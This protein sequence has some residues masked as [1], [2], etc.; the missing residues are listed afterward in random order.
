[1]KL[2]HKF[3]IGFALL[4]LLI[5]LF[6]GAV[7]ILSFFKVDYFTDMMSF[8]Q[9]RPF[10]VSGALFWIITAATGGILF[11][12]NEIV[13]QDRWSKYLLTGF[14]TL[15]MLTITTIL[16]SY[17]FEQY[18]GREYWEFPPFYNLLL[19]ISWLLL[20]VGFFVPIIRYASSKPVYIWMWSA[21][22]LFFL[23]TFIE[24]NLWHFAWF[25][26]SFVKEMTIQ[27][28][29]NGSMVGAWNQMIYGTGIY[30]MVKISGD[31]KIAQSGKAYFAFF[32][33]LTN[34]VFNWGHHIYNIPSASW[35]RGISYGISMTEWLLFISIIQ[36]FKIKLDETKKFS[37]L[38]TYRFLIASE[39][40]IF[41]NLLLALLMSIPAI[42]RYTHGT[43][44]TVAHAMGTT[45]G[46][47]TMILLASFSYMLKLDTIKKL[48]NRFLYLTGF[49]GTQI[50][51]LVFWVALIVAG[52]FKGLNMAKVPA[53]SFAE[54]MQSV[55]PALKV[56]MYSGFALMISLSIIVIYLLRSLRTLIIEEATQKLG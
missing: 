17:A 31:E 11:Y 22:I 47:N 28:K 30:L 52:L 39:V 6:F 24:Q 7:A 36:S 44:I 5:C 49:W 54:T 19:L 10:H 3:Y 1:M 15:M 16:I 43:H 13:A 33:G 29:S 37:H 27:W 8:Q 20:M 40:W 50:S 32:L 34:L 2:L 9:A 46:I 51:L 41:L 48:S 4:L 42:N 56:F 14:M 25:R 55:Y 53:L 18:G 12:K 45:I 23:F 38:I 21:G 35:I 26:N